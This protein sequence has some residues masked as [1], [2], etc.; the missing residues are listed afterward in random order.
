MKILFLKEL[1]IL[2]ILKQFYNSSS[3]SGLFCNAAGQVPPVPSPDKMQRT[4]KNKRMVKI[5]KIEKIT[6]ILN[7]HSVPYFIENSRILADSMLSG[8]EIFESVIDVTEVSR[9]ELY[10]WLGY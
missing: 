8:T 4:E 7:T 6:K 3:P 5:M 1:V 9:D 10:E 2:I